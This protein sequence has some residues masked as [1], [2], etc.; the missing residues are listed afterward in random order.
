MNIGQIISNKILE[1]SKEQNEK[2]DE[3]VYFELNNWFCGR[4][5]PPDGN[6]KTW[7]ESSQFNNDTWC[8]ENKI[9]VRSGIIDM[10]ENWCITATKD[11]VEK[12]CP[13]LLTDKSYTYIVC[14]YSCGE[15]TK[16]EEQGYYAQFLRHRD[17]EGE[18]YGTFGWPFLEYEEGNF[19]STYYSEED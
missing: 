12:W 4:D 9:C 1:R 2:M 5:Y 11:W 16:K 13:E 6:L 14:M 18:V 19:G 7:V 15:H 10:S 8:K 3:I 17:E